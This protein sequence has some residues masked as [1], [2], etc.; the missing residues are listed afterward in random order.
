MKE[1]TNFIWSDFGMCERVM[2]DHW[3][4][5]PGRGRM[6][7]TSNSGFRRGARGGHIAALSGRAIRTCEDACRKTRSAFE[8]KSAS[9][10]KSR[11]KAPMHTRSM[12]CCL[13]Y[14]NTSR[15]GFPHRTAFSTLHCR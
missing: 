10:P 3:R 4:L 11:P 12:F 2:S 5:V 15:Y 6:V 1:F 9:D 14:V 8:P 13:E 7:Y